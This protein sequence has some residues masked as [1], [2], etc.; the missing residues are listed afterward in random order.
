MNTVK[1]EE[2]VVLPSAEDIAA[3]KAGN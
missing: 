2:K 1:T 3:E